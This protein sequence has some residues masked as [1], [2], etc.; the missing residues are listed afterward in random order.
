MSR[1]KEDLPVGPDKDSSLRVVGA[2]GSG[3]RWG[4]IEAVLLVEGINYS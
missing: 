4:N 1:G 3:L 2:I